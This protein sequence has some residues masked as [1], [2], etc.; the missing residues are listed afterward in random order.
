MRG[1]I[2]QGYNRLKLSFQRFIGRSAT[3]NQ[4]VTSSRTAGSA[5]QTQQSSPSSQSNPPVTQSMLEARY[6]KG[7]VQ[8]GGG[9]S[10]ATRE[11]VHRNVQAS[12]NGNAQVRPTEGNRKITLESLRAKYGENNVQQGGG[13]WLVT[14]ERV[15]R[16]IQVNRVGNDRARVARDRRLDHSENSRSRPEGYNQ[17]TIGRNNPRYNEIL[18][19]KI[20]LNNG[21]PT[22]SPAPLDS[23]N[24][25]QV[26]TGRFPLTG[27]KPNAILYRADHD[28]SI[29]SYATYDSN[30]MILKR[31]DM[32]GA[33]HLRVNPP[34]VIEYGRNDKAPDGIVRVQSPDR[35][36]KPRKP[37][38]SELQYYKP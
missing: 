12:R 15:N 35:K 2:N 9:N 13:N 26:P 19:R 21:I 36:I 18:Q 33:P 28:G 29:T 8:R 32:K 4:A 11:R 6:G 24:A 37:L 34:H 3:P 23:P 1:S 7:N 17:L 30:G 27:E 14:R 22:R 10:L 25:R 38:P 16:N 20:N 5:T 31:V